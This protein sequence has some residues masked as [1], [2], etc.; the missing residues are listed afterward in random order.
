MG[1]DGRVVAVSVID[2]YAGGDFLRAGGGLVFRI[3]KWNG[4]SWSALGSGMGGFPGYIGAVFALAASGN[5]IYA[6]GFFATAGGVDAK[7]IA[8]WNGS[9]WSAL[10]SGV[11]GAAYPFAWS[12]AESGSDVY[13]RSECATA[14][15]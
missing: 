14:G 4:S 2:V 13:V 3:A 5:D 11:T 10:G 1:G 12:R 15:R 9:T 6:G 7:D 8:K